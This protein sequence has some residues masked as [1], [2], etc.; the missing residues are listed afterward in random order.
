MGEVGR[1][2]RRGR[3]EA[4]EGKEVYLCLRKTLVNECVWGLGL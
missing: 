1:R 4:R 2:E 3:K